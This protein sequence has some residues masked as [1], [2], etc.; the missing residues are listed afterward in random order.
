[1]YYEGPGPEAQGQRLGTALLVFRWK[2]SGRRLKGIKLKAKSKEFRSQNPEYR[3]KQ[4]KN[5]NS[6]KAKRVINSKLP[7]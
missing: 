7:G 1:L 6:L 4:T 5:V 3:R 2:V